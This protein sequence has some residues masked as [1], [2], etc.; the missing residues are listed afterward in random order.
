MVTLE[1][2]IPPP[3]VMAVVAGAM[4]WSVDGRYLQGGGVAIILAALAALLAVAVIGAAW[5]SFRRRR[6]TV[7]PLAPATATALVV[8]GVFCYSRNPMYLGMLLL[9]VA[10]ALLGGFGWQWLGVPIYAGYISR[11]QIAPEE[12]AMAELFGADYQA[13][14]RQVHRWLGRRSVAG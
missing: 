6:T 12:R 9:L 3:V 10:V 14:C 8:E 11:W 4:V 7:N 1:N 5:L 13:Y 2:K